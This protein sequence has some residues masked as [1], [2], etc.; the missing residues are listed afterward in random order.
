METKTV[1]ELVIEPSGHPHTMQ[2]KGGI[3]VEDLG[4]SSLMLTVKGNGVVLHG[5]HGTIA[6]EAPYVQKI[7]QQELNPITKIHRN[8][9]D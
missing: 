4:N 7:N 3:Q 2:A 5:E 9:F 1:N 6:T 8:A